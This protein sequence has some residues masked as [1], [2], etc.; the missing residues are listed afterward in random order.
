MV[1][2]KRRGISGS[3]E[4]TISAQVLTHY[5][6]TPPI[7][8]EVDASP[9]D[10]GAVTTHSMPNGTD[11][12]LDN[13]RNVFQVEKKRPIA[14]AFHTLHKSEKNYAQTEK[15]A[16]ALTSGVKKFHQY[17]YGRT[18]TLLSD[19]QP[20]TTIF[21]PEKNVPPLAAARLQRWAI[22]LAAYN[23]DICYKPTKRTL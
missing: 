9:Y 7:K 15:E 3:K 22:L 12:T 18:F 4:E 21:S 19:H 1:K 10:V 11:R 13:D 5:D 8:L 20:L 23:Y 17:L 16:L 2:Q 14:F 6:P